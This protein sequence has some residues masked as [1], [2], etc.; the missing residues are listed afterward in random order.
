M[1]AIFDA[2][3]GQEVPVGGIVAGFRKLWEDSPAEE[4]RAVQLNLVLHL[5]SHSTPADATEQF[6]N[7][8]RFA[9]RYP[10]RVVVLCPDFD[11][12]AP[13][14]MRAKI[15]GECFL[16]KSK[17]DTRCVEFVILHYTMPVRHHLENQVSI[18]LSS[19]MPLYYWG[20]K[21]SVTKRLADYDYLLTRSQRILFDSALVPPDA[22][23]FPWPNIAAVRDLAYTRTLPL[24][25]NIGQF[26]SR[27]APPLITGGLQK[28]LIRH[29]A[30]LGAEASCLLGWV[31]KGLVRSGANVD[32][33]IAFTV[34]P[35]DCPG[36][37]SLEFTYADP[38][39]TF[40]WAADLAKNEAGFTGDLGTGRS[41]QTVG[42]HLLAP[43]M[44]LSEAMFF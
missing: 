2:L 19:D 6:E 42:A 7:T 24:R 15:Y 31:K 30:Q 32:Q 35:V 3:P 40:R 25:Q 38:K 16:G 14:E 22:F 39:K 12:S 34:T 43:E 4:S 44:A 20:H 33:G 36:C 21:F 27:Y 18:C 5:G 28:V 8:L 29:R 41:T 37:F 26:L 13:E 10:C 11:P 9:Q 17:N 23:T 1:P